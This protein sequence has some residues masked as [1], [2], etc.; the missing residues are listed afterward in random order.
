MEVVDEI[1]DPT[2]NHVEFQGS[3]VGLPVGGRRSRK[4]ARIFVLWSS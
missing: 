3:W 2:A 1:C 4:V